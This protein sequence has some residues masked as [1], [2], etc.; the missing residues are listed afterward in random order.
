MTA[1]VNGGAFALAV[2]A[3]ILWGQGRTVSGALVGVAAFV[4][5]AGSFILK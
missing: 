4:A 5:G 3:G 2:F 1:Y